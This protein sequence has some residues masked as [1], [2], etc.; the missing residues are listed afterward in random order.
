MR[1]TELHKI[2][3]IAHLF[4]SPMCLLLGLGTSC[5]RERAAGKPAGVTGW[6]KSHVFEFMVSVHVGFSGMF[7]YILYFSHFVLSEL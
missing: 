1:I 7:Y 5:D 3:N 6:R 4:Q 2:W